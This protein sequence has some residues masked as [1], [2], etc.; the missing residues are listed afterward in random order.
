LAGFVCSLVAVHL[1]DVGDFGP[2]WFG[3]N[4]ARASLPILCWMVLARHPDAD[5]LSTRLSSLAVNTDG[6]EL[7]IASKHVS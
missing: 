3:L 7:A 6:T 4:A 5:A 1:D 2:A